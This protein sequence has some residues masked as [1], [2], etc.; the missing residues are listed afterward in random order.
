M[1]TP[2]HAI[3]NLAL[4]TNTQQ[5]QAMPWI[6]LGAVLPDIPIFLF[7]GWAKLI[8][9]QLEQVIWGEM[10]FSPG[11]QALIHGAHSIPLA[12]LGIAIGHYA[13]IWQ[14]KVLALSALLHS[15]LDLPLHHDDAHRHFLPFSNYRFIS[16]ISYWDPKHH[17]RWVALAELGMVLVAS[18]RIFPLVKPWLGKG[19]LILVNLV[20][21]I[22]YWTMYARAA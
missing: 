17:A 16:P 2:S 14:L 4:L 3:I 10:Y 13:G 20:Y 19:L 1:N 9:Q 7:Y 15:G 5:P 8:L 12:L 21:W 18:L 6:T 22:F 11:W